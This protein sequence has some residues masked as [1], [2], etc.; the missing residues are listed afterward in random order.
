M[1]D[2]GSGEEPTHFVIMKG[3]G[4]EHKKYRLFLNED[5]SFVVRK[6]VLNKCVNPECTLFNLSP[7]QKLCWICVEKKVEKLE[8]LLD[9]M[10]GAAPGGDIFKESVSDW[11]QR[12]CPH[13]GV[14]SRPTLDKK[15]KCGLCG[16]ESQEAYEENAKRFNKT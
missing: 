13:N 3:T 6:D 8:K 9:N 4:G 12:T 15:P 14:W 1:S 11:Y 10:I 16:L 5:E 2:R 7:H